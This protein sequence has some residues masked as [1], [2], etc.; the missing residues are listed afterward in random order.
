VDPGTIF[1]WRNYPNLH[2]E[3]PKD[4]WCLYWGK[5]DSFIDPVKVIFHK[6]TSQFHYYETCGEREKHKICDMKKSEYSFFEAEHSI[7]DFTFPCM[8]DYET[9]YNSAKIDVIFKL[10]ED[11]IRFFYNHIKQPYAN[12]EYK[13]KCRIKE[14]L[15][16]SGING[17]EMPKRNIQRPY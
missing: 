4:I 15:N 2:Y 3:G 16:N 11:K 6:F 14:N 13:I 12:I 7:I 10:P 8:F 1:I 9:G 5:T 17:L